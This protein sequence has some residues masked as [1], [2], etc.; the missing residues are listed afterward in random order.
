M[1]AMFNRFISENLGI[2]PTLSRYVICHIYV[3][4]ETLI[5]VNNDWI[6]AGMMDLLQLWGADI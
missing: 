1:W 6:C 3:V 5:E 2:Q 4:I